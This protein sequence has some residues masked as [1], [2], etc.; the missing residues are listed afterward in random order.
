MYKLIVQNQC[1]EKMIYVM[2]KLRVTLKEH[3]P[4]LSIVNRKQEW[5]GWEYS[6]GFLRHYFVL[7]P[8][9]NINFQPYF[10]L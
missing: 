6:N 5:N 3:K 1:C 7:G 8:H 2:F 10:P 9:E 4:I